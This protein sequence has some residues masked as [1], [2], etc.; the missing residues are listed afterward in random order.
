MHDLFQ[1]LPAPILLM[2][3]KSMPDLQSLY[4]L[5]QASTI[6]AGIFEDCPS[7]I[8][9]TVLSH[10]PEELRQII[11][12]VA[13][14]LTDSSTHFDAADDSLPTDYDLLLQVSIGEKS[15]IPLPSGVSASTV[16][17]LLRLACRMHQIAA[18]F[19]RAYIDR[20]NSLKPSHLLNPKDCLFNGPSGDYPEGRRDTPQQTGPASW[21]EQYRVVR[22]L[23]RL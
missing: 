18:T 8:V 19:P 16:S 12:A 22:A 21:V 10:L 17:G 23:W 4:L 20:V 13:I 7:E 9:E 14:A 2:V 5:V 15:G 1:L 3:I 6:A 11:Y